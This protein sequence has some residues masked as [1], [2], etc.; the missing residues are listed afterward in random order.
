MDGKKQKSYVPIAT[1]QTGD[2]YLMD[3]ETHAI[4]RRWPKK[5]RS[6]KERV[7]ARRKAAKVQGW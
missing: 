1:T 7:R 5:F 3:A 2:E 4:R 6:K